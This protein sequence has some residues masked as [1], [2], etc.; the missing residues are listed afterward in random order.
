MQRNPSGTLL[1]H[2]D[3]H[4]CMCRADPDFR[5]G[6]LRA[7]AELPVVQVVA[8]YTDIPPLPQQKSSETCRRP[9]A[10]LL[11]DVGTIMKARLPMEGIVENEAIQLQVATLRVTIGLALQK[12]LAGLHFESSKIDQFLKD[13]Q[14]TL[15]NADND[16][17]GLEQCIQDCNKKWID[18]SEEEQT[19]LVD[20]LC[21]IKE[22]D[23]RVQE[24]RFSQ[25][26]AL[27][28]ILT[29]PLEAL[30]RDR[31]PN[32]AANRLHRQCQMLFKF[33][34]GSGATAQVTAGKVLEHAYLWTTACRSNK[35]EEIQFGQM[36]VPFQCKDVQPGYIF[37]ENRSLDSAK[38]AEM[39]TATLYYVKG[40]HPCADMFFKDNDGALYLVDVGGTSDMSKAQKKIQKMDE[41]LMNESVRDD[42]HVAGVKGVVLLPNIESIKASATISAVAITRARARKLLG[43]L[44]QLLAWLPTA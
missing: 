15:R 28:D 13:L 29:A 18:D 14:E 20:L 35:F 39:Q 32:D 16:V 11:T 36:V 31:D 38:V 23:R 41:V 27:E 8:T 10:C 42:L 12:L 26:V 7:L 24:K 30:L 43:G 3:E 4:R 5:R 37:Q 33:A 40:N 44:A 34:L 22:N 6:A 19:S 1:V 9:I 21:C 2:I 25:V 17:Q